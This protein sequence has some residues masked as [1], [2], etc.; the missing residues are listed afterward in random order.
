V[1]NLTQYNSQLWGLIISATLIVVLW[2]LPFG[3]HIIYPFTILSTW[4]HEMSHGLTAWA[5]GAEFSDLKLYSSG[6]G[7]ARYSY[8]SPLL[9][10]NIGHALVAAG[11]PLGPVLAG[12]LFIRMGYYPHLVR[13]GL[14]IFSSLL[15]LS[16]ILWVRTT[17]GILMILATGVVIGLIA[18]FS[19]I[20]WQRFALQF[21]GVQACISS[22]QQ[23]DYLFTYEVNIAGNTML[24]DTG[25]IADYLGGSHW[26]WAI[27]ITV[28]S[29]W[30][31]YIS[32]KQPRSN[33]PKT[34]KNPYSTI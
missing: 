24:S 31:L 34:T 10:G 30:L 11:G 23:L 32:L 13:W 8:S 12:A 16:V 19:N 3:R 7:V 21:L 17:F 29:I 26:F 9:F 33:K 20:H 25:Q 15:L 18:I 1:L 4:F 28:F 2:Q 5:L 27:L 6:S 14:F 22:Y